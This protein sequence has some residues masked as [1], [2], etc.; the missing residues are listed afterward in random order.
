M[1]TAETLVIGR[2]GVVVLAATTALSVSS[3]APREDVAEQSGSET[4]AL[5]GFDSQVT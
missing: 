5:Y 3:C 1:R 2:L 4:S